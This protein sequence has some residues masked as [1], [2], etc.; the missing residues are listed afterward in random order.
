MLE[1]LMGVTLMNKLQAILLM[2]AEF[3]AANKTIFGEH[4]LDNV[5]KYKQMPEEIFSEK[6]CLADD[7]SLSKTL[8]YDIVR[9]L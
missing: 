7:R 3:N 8:F 2:D 6:N 4:L 5:Q 1:K 9:Q